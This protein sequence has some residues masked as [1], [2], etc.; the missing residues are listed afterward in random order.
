M[1][2]KHGSINAIRTKDDAFKT[3]DEAQARRKELSSKH[4]KT[5]FFWVRI[6]EL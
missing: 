6:L 4:S 3:V 2:Q 1:Q 5:H